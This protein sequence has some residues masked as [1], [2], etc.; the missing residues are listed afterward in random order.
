MARARTA[1]KPKTAPSS[2]QPGDV[3]NIPPADTFNK[4]SADKQRSSAS[5]RTMLRIFGIPGRKTADCSPVTGAFKKRIVT[6]QVGPLKVSGLDIAV[7]SL[8]AV[9]AEAAQQIPNV[10]DQLKT[11]GMLCVRH[12][13][14][15]PNSF[16]N[17]SW[18]TA[19]DLFFGKSVIP[20]G[21]HKTHRGLLQLA[22]FFNHHGWFWGAGFSG[23]SVNSMHFELSEQAIVS[24]EA[25][26]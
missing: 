11:A 19:I 7:T 14:L 8:E 26:S 1:T 4:D 25:K 5:E 2:P 18:G 10:V 22:P 3:V 24:A 6:K 15:D 23:K 9:L 12:K 20:Q 13:R 17:H 21:S 16:S